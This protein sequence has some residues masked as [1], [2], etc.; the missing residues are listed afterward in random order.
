[1]V[2]L[3]Q[4]DQQIGLAAEIRIE[5]AARVAG[6]RRD[7]LDARRDIAFLQKNRLRGIQQALARLVF[8]LLTG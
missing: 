5:R 2:A 1:M 6:R 3:E 4:L 8:A 7:V